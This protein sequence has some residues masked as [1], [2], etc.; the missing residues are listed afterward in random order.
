ML[1]SAREA[2]DSGSARAS[3]HRKADQGGSDS[4]RPTNHKKSASS[5]E[6]LKFAKASVRRG[7]S[8]TR[9]ESYNRDEVGLENRCQ[10]DPGFS[11]VGT[12]D[13]LGYYVLRQ[14]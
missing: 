3:C 14:N 8:A 12:R 1:R 4:L 10:N 13:N 7:W 5:R 9:G 6:K 2:S 11:A